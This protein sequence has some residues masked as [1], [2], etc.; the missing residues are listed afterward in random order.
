MI[1]GPAARVVQNADDAGRALVARGRQSELLDELRIARG[2]GD[3]ARARVRDVRQERAER[4]DE[5]D[6]ELLSELH[7]LAGEGAPTRARLD[8]EQEHRVALGMRRDDGNGRVEEGVVRP[9]DVP[10]LPSSSDT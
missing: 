3:R 1:D 9:V 5:L 4:D 6:F 2:A 8:A 7:D 10:R